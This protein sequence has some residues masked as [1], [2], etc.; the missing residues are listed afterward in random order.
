[1]IHRCLPVLGFLL[2]SSQAF[3]ALPSPEAIAEFHAAQQSIQDLTQITADV[4]KLAAQ[5]NSDQTQGQAIV[6]QMSQAHDRVFAHLEKAI[7][8]G[9]AVA[10]HMK[11]KL[12]FAK[13]PLT[14]KEP[15][16]ALY[17][18]A[19]ALGLVAGAV[20]YA[21]CLPLVPHTVEQGK[22]LA[23]LESVIDG[24]DPYQTEYP[25]LTAFPDCFPKNKP[26][27]NPEEE[28]PVEWIQDNAR[29]QALSYEDF[30]AEGYYTLALTSGDALP[31][32]RRAEFLSSAFAHGC[33]GDSARIA[34]HLGVTVPS[35]PK[36]TS[37]T[38]G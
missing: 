16:C 35:P 23:I 22:R 24:P 20:E 18:Q 17:G 15:A 6:A 33:R 21:K 31:K 4:L 8:S 30:R 2:I 12:L 29:P 14:N 1:M 19:A 34:K 5:K 11:G 28:D 32:T 26:A 38:G 36:S 10:M 7:A 9:H 13:N 25:L 27:L 3:A 37:P